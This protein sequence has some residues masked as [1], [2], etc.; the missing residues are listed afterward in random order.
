MLN[1]IHL[2][3]ASESA[4]PSL[5]SMVKLYAEKMKFDFENAIWQAANYVDDCDVRKV[6][7]AYELL[8]DAVRIHLLMSPAMYEN[9][10]DFV[11]S[12]RSYES[13]KELFL[14]IESLV[15]DE[16]AVC[17]SE[18]ELVH[19]E[20]REV[21]SAMGDVGLS[22]REETGWSRFDAERL[23]SL[24]VL[25]FDSP[26]ARMVRPQS[27]T[28]RLPAED[29]SEPERAAVLAKCNRAFDYVA[30]TAPSFAHMIRNYTRAVRLRK[31]E[32]SLGI[33]SEHVTSTIGEIRLL[34]MQRDT[35]DDL[36]VAEMLIHESVHNLLSTYEYVQGAF[37]S[38]PDKK[39][40]RPTS[41]W[42]GNPLP[43]AS[44]THAIFVWFALFNFSILESEKPGLSD[45]E[46]H[47]IHERRNRYA[48]G[49]VG[50]VR[51]VDHLR[52]G[53]EFSQEVLPAVDAVQDTVLL[54]LDRITPE[55]AVA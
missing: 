55:A 19:D 32:K 36:K 53:I 21:W 43:I 27:S 24:M 30:A 3:T 20:R 41:P 48:A 1:I 47:R 40:C 44:F 26:Y 54:T 22:F 8:P 39:Q 15:L 37:L 25:D 7:E 16:L 4:P 13:S 2:L 45:E 52:G 11:F 9:V 18:P 6:V 49:F 23:D 31:G 35:V 50:P 12:G 42:T 33:S 46:L 5:D 29:F 28:M 34:N 51:L 17:R 14:R 38:T 10:R